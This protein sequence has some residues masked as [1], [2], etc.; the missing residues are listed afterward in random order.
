MNFFGYGITMFAGA[1]LLQ[2]APC[3][4]GVSMVVTTAAGTAGYVCEPFDCTPNLVAA[5]EKEMVA[6]DVFGG[7]DGVYALLVGWP[8]VDCLSFP[9]FTGEL[10]IGDPVITVEVG[11]IGATGIGNP[12]KADVASTT[13]QMPGGIPPGVGLCLQ[14]VSFSSIDF[15]CGFTR[16][17]E[18]VVK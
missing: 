6:V 5:A 15:Y 11:F 10:A 14:A 3:Q 1:C 17:T 7:A 13:Y 8:T 12:C 9:G 2:A 4:S 16:P 18:L